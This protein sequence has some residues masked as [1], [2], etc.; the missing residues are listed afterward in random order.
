MRSGRWVL[1]GRRS[2]VP[3]GRRLTLQL[4]LKNV[5]DETYYPSSGASNV[6]VAVGEPF[7]ALMTARVSW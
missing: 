1:F 5:L 3:F 2:W 4:N 7:Q 6:L